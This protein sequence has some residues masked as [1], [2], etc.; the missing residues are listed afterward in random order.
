MQKK[1][2]SSVIGLLVVVALFIMIEI[3]TRSGLFDQSVVETVIDQIQLILISIILALGLNLITGITGQF[4]LGHAGFMAIG[5][6]TTTLILPIV[7][8]GE[9]AN[10]FIIVV[11]I[12]AGTVAA[13][14]AGLLVGIPILRLKGDY[15]AI[16]TLG[17]GE[18]VKI[19]IESNSKTLG[20][21]TGLI[22]RP[23]FLS[24]ELIF[25]VCVISF[26]LIKNLLNSSYGRSFISVREDEVA[27]ESMG[28]NLTKAKVT[29]FVIGT[30]FAG[31]AGALSVGKY[32]SVT[33]TR[34]GFMASID[35]L[36][37]VVIGGLGN[38]YGTVIA[39]IIMQI[40]V[41]NLQNLPEIRMIVYGLLLIIIMIV[42][43][44]NNPIINSVRKFIS[45]ISSKIIN[46]FKKVKS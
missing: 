40:M 45:N 1:S 13:G 41:S 9:S 38:I 18:I 46:I 36:L 3:F 30:A 7:G 6:Y 21:A 32:G 37:I 35:V 15:L 26:I 43:S 2:I 29:A 27:S 42:K 16:A 28:I 19:I 8:Y 4:S 14:L 23:I 10:P 20:G 11:A 34:F 17:V 25:I 39:A 12:L 44:G 22:D 5:A 33:P 24:T 31:L